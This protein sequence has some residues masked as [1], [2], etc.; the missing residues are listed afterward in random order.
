MPQN[1]FVLC[2]GRCGSTTFVQASAHMTNFTS[3]HESRT[4]IHGASKFDYPI[5]HI[6]ADN[7][8]SWHLGRLNEQ[9]GDDAW[10]VHLTRD[11]EEVAL[12]YA[13]RKNRGIAHFYHHAI[14]WQSQGKRTAN[15]YESCLD[16]VDTVNSNIS[17]FLRD[18]SNVMAMTLENAKADF[19]RF[20]DWIGAEGDK[21]AA[22]A[23]WDV[24]HNK[25]E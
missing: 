3:G 4:H 10:Y 13:K 15:R 18:K 12:S 11:R 25:S 8:L 7:R 17:Y 24:K 20:W 16:Y 9:W 1:I 6:E 19:A 14:L 21:S 5:G 2:T 22:L 23:E